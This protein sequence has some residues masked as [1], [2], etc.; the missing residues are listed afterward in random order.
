MADAVERILEAPTS[1]SLDER[2]T[3]RDQALRALDRLPAAVGCLILEC[4]QTATVDSAGL[5][6]LIAIQRHAARR[7][8]RVRLR[9]VRDELRFLLMLTKLADL[10]DMED[11]EAF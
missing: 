11:V 7:E 2:A 8:Q 4:S 6:A 9:G 3:F 1:L 10:F 5:S